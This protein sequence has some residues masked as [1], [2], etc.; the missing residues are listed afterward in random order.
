MLASPEQPN[1]ATR[2]AEPEPTL[3][4]PLHSDSFGFPYQPYT[5]QEDFMKNLYSALEQ[6]QVG[7]FES[8][9]GTG[10]TLSIICGSLKWLND[11]SQRLDIAKET[12]QSQLIQQNTS[13][14]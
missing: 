2:Q 1:E 14:R 4:V 5:I 3:P 6:R 8:P 10:K 13:G 12:L 7:I 11:H 9:T